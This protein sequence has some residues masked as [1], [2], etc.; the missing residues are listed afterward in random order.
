MLDAIYQDI[1][2]DFAFSAP[3]STALYNPRGWFYLKS[4]YICVLY[5]IYRITAMIITIILINYGKNTVKVYVTPK[6]FIAYRF[7]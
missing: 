1:L 2:A 7:L 3:T 6:I 4:Q 5:F